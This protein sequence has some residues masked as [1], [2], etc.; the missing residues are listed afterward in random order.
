[1]SGRTNWGRSSG[2]GGRC[3]PVPPRGAVVN[4]GVEWLVF[5]KS[6][7]TLTDVV[8]SSRARGPR[9]S[10]R[11]RWLIGMRLVRAHRLVAITIATPMHWGYIT[12]SGHESHPGAVSFSL[13]DP[14]V[15]N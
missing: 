13:V 9:S 11:S 4:V 1:M 10:R 5:L 6:V 15:A 3:P 14:L 7:A 2:E 12:L 8:R